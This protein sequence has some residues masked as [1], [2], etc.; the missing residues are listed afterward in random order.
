[1]EIARLCDPREMALAAAARRR[2]DDVWC[3]SAGRA[4]APPVLVVED[5]DDDVVFVGEKRAHEGDKR[6]T[7]RPAAGA[8]PV[9]VSRRAANRRRVG[10]AA[11][12]PVRSNP[13]AEAA[14]RRAAQQR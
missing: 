9:S 6:P 5:D 10:A 12:V 2:G 13:A 7:P 14:L 4:G 3:G 8:R 11:R 1:M